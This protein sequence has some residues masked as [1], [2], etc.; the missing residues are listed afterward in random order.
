MDTASI[1]IVTDSTGD[2]PPPL[3]QQHDIR[4]VPVNIQFGQETCEE[5]VTIDCTTF[6]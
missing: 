4:V 3:L 1:G 6:L 2:V 5:N